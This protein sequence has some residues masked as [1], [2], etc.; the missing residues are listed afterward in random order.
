MTVMS[1]K[2]AYYRGFFNIYEVKVIACEK[3][4]N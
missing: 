1:D 2:K 3:Y 4:L